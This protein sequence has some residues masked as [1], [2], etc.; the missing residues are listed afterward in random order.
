MGSDVEVIV[1]GSAALLDVAAARIAALESRWSRFLPDSEISLLNARSGEPVAV[2]DDTVALITRAQE[3]WRFTGA[4]FEPLVLGDLLRAG[5]TT[6]FEELPADASLA[7]NDLRLGACIDIVVDGSTITLPGGTGFDPGGI[8][9]GLAAD[10]VTVE[11]LAAGADG[12]CVNMGGDVRAAGLSP[13]GSPG[14]T[15]DVVHP[16]LQQ[17]LCAVGIV[18]GAVATSTTLRRRWTVDGEVRHHLIDPRTGA[19]STSDIDLVTVVAGDAWAAEVLAKAVLLRGE[20][21]FDIVAGTGAEALLV[22]QSGDV[23]V[24]SG[25]SAFTGGVEPPAH[26]PPST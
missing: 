23:R 26:L 3:A 7:H 18:D 10:L 21:P 19:P 16:H 4:L 20:H 6:T 1:V 5:Y 8:G 17:R 14:W 15:I 9:K 22:T 24:T 2:S 12:A 11:L 25:F 13:S